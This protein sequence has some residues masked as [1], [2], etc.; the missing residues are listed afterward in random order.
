M[1][2]LVPAEGDRGRIPSIEPECTLL[3]LKGKSQCMV[4]G[5]VHGTGESNT[6]IQITEGL[7][8]VL[9]DGLKIAAEKLGQETRPFAM[10]R[11]G[12]A[13]SSYEPRGSMNDALNLAVTAVGELHGG[14]GTPLR[15]VYDSLTACSFLRRR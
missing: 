7:G 2:G 12:T 11:K 5:H 8:D 3:L 15:V 10:T 14:R 4:P 9:A 13:L 6:H 1:G